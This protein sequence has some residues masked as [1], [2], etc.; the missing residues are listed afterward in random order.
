MT[1]GIDLSKRL[2]GGHLPRDQAAAHAR[3][4]SLPTVRHERAHRSADDIAR[5]RSEKSAETRR[6]SGK[7]VRG[8]AISLPNSRPPKGGV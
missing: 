5:A 4:A 8:S 2:H 1:D 7:P 6:R 3:L